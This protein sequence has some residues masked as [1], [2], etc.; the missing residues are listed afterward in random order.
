MLDSSRVAITFRA[1]LQ[2][3]AGMFVEVP[4]EVLDALAS[5]KRRA[6]VRVV[7]NG[8]EL[9]TTLAVYSDKSYIGFRKE[10]REAAGL[11]P[12]EEVD[13]AVELDTARL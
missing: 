8:V 12:G 5:P 4:T 7:V 1:K 6:P 9:P 2:F 11:V 13:V 3:Q 10:I